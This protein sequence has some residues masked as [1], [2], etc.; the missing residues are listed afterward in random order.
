VLHDAAGHPGADQVADTQGQERQ[1][2]LR[3]G[4]DAR[5][6]LLVGVDLARHKEEVVAEAVE[7]DAGVQHPERR[8]GVAPGKEEVPHRPRE[9]ADQEDPSDAQPH[10]KPRQQEHEAD[11][12]HLAEGHLAGRLRQADLVEEEIG[13]GIVELERNAEQ[14]RPDHEGGEGAVLEERQRVEAQHVTHAQWLAAGMGRG[15]GQEETEEPHH[16][17]GPGCQV[18]G[19]GGGLQAQPPHHQPGHDP[20]DR[21]EDPDGGE[22]L[23][24]VLHMGEGDRV[25]QRQ[26]RHVAEAV[27]DER[28]VECAEGRERGRPPE[29][30]GTD[31]VQQRQDPFGREEAVGHHPHEEWG[32][33]GGNGERAVGQADL[34]A[35]KFEGGAEV[36]AH[37]DEPGT[38]DEELQ[39]HHHRELELRA[40]GSTLILI[41]RYATQSP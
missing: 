17:R 10:Q 12:R 20:S 5:P 31:Q 35:G 29:H 15:V 33:D 2:S 16:N 18:H 28:Q 41:L 34:S 8:A 26:R 25:G 32:H 40:H 1:E 11:F 38:P 4:P 21:S 23:A 22:L 19:H 24:R 13:E 39:E 9:H 14:E 6:R 27:A 30:A 37:G 36:G 3:G 7:E